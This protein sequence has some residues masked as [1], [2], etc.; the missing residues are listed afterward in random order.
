MT[1]FGTYKIPKRHCPNHFGTRPYVGLQLSEV[2]RLGLICW[3]LLSVSLVAAA[4]DVVKLMDDGHWKR[5]RQVVDA[6]LKSNPQDARALYWS[7]KVQASFGNLERGLSA[8][9]RAAEIEPR[10]P[11]FLAQLAEMHARLTDRVSVLKQVIYIRQFKKEV[12]AAL[13]INPRH[14]DTM[15]VDIMFKSKAPLVAGGDRKEAHSMAERLAQIDPR[16]GYLVQARLAE[17]DRAD[18]RIEQ[19]LTKAVAAAP[20]FYPAHFYL[21]KFYCCVAHVSRPD[22]AIQQAKEMIR[23]DSGQSGG[24]DILARVY[25]AGERWPELEGVLAESEAKVPDDLGPYYQAASILAAQG[26]DGP[27]AERYLKKYL[28]Q[29][30]EGR[31]PTVQEGRRLLAAVAGRNLH[32]SSEAGL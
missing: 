31:Q 25:A 12:E 6:R 14:V 7:S 16:W 26:K 5:A 10:N 4:Q 11:D 15:L 9:E 23:L 21:A 24:Y 29:E 18:A 30:P 1:F 2:H 28:T 22:A 17:Q 27:R 8:A 13:A 19:A 32:A 20:G 3:G